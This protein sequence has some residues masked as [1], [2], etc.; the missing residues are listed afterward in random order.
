VQAKSSGRDGRRRRRQREVAKDKYPVVPQ[1]VSYLDGVKRDPA[2]QRRNVPLR[3]QGGLPH[4]QQG[5]YRV[6]TS[7]H[8]PARV[9]GA[10]WPRLGCGLARTGLPGQVIAPLNIKPLGRAWFPYQRCRG[11]TG[12]GGT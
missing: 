4:Q 12:S 7:G 5:R 8:H 2:Q 3:G 6:T 9:A 10:A 1:Q 11:A